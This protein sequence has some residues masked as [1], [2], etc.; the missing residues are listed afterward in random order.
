MSNTH[1][2]STKVRKYQK[3]LRR[4]R[5]VIIL[6]TFSLSCM[7]FIFWDL[8]R[9]RFTLDLYVLLVAVSVLLFLYAFVLNALDYIHYR[10]KIHNESKPLKES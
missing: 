6:L 10:K 2:A 3:H 8:L 1:I 9:S 7:L 5:V 4:I